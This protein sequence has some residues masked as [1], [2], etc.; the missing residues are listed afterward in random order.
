[1]LI[2]FNGGSATLSD[3]VHFLHVFRCI[4]F[5]KGIYISTEYQTTSIIYIYSADLYTCL[6]SSMSILLLYHPICSWIECIFHMYS[7][8]MQKTSCIIFHNAKPIDYLANI[9]YW[10]SCLFYTHS[11]VIY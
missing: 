9:F 3:T 5:V 4:S 7:G 6:W 10:I 1:M 11:I 8:Q 2:F